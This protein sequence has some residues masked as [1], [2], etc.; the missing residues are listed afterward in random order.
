MRAILAA[1][2]GTVASQGG[3]S[4]LAS[5]IE[6]AR[7]AE[8]AGAWDEA[9]ARFE[10]ALVLLSNGGD[11]KSRA[12]ILR[13]IGTVHRERGELEPAIEKY[14]AS[15]D[16]AWKEGLN[17]CAAAALNCLGAVEQYRGNLEEAKARYLEA[18]SIAKTIGDVRLVGMLEQNLGI[19]YNIQ[20]DLHLAL[21]RYT[22]ALD[23][24]RRLADRPMEMRCLNNMGMV[25]IDLARW[26]DAEANFDAAITLAEQLQD[27][28]MLAQI[29]LNRSELHLKLR[30]FTG[31]RECCDL[32]FEIFTRVG[33][34][35]GQAEAHKFYG[36]LY[37]GTGKQALAESHLTQAVEL[38]R[39][40]GDRLLEAEAESER[41]LVHRELG[42]NPEALQSLNR[43]HR[44]FC[45]L[46]ARRELSKI[47]DRMD[48][49]EQNFLQVVRSWAESIE[50][51]DRYTV[52]HCERVAKFSCM[53][54]EA[55]GITGRELIWFRMGAFLHDVGKVVVPEEILNKPGK[56]TEKEWEVMRSHPVA[57]DEIVSKLDFPWDIRPMVRHHHEHWVGTGYP[58]KLAGEA[59]PL[60]ARILTV[61][62]VF[63]A[64]TTTRSYRPAYSHLE[65]I[66]IMERDSGRIFEPSL[67]KL[68]RDLM[69][70][71]RSGAL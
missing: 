41:A 17:E 24:Y 48:D 5:L 11:A 39:S 47:D 58:D 2:R 19:I 12:E 49:L 38:A 45:D 28:G 62:D 60:T 8:R 43:A 30:D 15:L 40:D 52:G 70:G 37:R 63:D 50:A 10:Q 20:G 71:K 13:W 56:L 16:L 32:A 9:L 64:L 36:I 1:V 29:A 4:G 7:T 46:Q 67:F 26:E 35:P 66:R 61:A 18:G 42:R 6:A 54:A 21:V 57:G 34:T 51:K 14:Q 23:I 59:I 22:T 55:V 3:A 65:A 44:I 69:M 33:S 53:L 68:F 27:T 25:N 31:A